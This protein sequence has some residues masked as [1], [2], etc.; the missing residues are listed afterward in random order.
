MRFPSVISRNASRNGK[1]FRLLPFRAANGSACTRSICLANIFPITRRFVHS[2]CAALARNELDRP[3]LIS[4]CRS[5]DP[6]RTSGK[7]HGQQ[8]RET[9]LPFEDIKRRIK[10]HSD[11]EN[12]FLSMCNL[13]SLC[14]PASGEFGIDAERFRA[15]RHTQLTSPECE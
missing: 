8:Q 6:R 12:R 11:A 3:L 10:L 4:H 2:S 13:A 14:C 7:C 1:I 15:R 9:V 5:I